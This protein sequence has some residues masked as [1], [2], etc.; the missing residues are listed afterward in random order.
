MYF[1]IEEFLRDSRVLLRMPEA[2][3]SEGGSFRDQEV[4]H[5]GQEIGE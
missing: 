4:E 1:R 2:G 5:A 3:R